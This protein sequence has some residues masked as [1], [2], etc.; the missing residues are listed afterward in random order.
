MLSSYSGFS[1]CEA[2]RPLL[3]HVLEPD[4]EAP[5]RPRGCRE[6]RC[7]SGYLSDNWQSATDIAKH[8]ERAS[9]LTAQHTYT[10]SGDHNSSLSLAEGVLS[11]IRRSFALQRATGGLP[12][13]NDP[14]SRS[15]S[16]PPSNSR[17]LSP[18]TK[19]AGS[20]GSSRLEERLRASL[21]KGTTVPS[22]SSTPNHESQTPSESP[23]EAG[24]SDALP[25]PHARIDQ[26]T[27]PS[28]ILGLDP[29]TIPLPPSPQPS[30]FVGQ[31][32][33]RLV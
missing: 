9:T 6:Q 5:R 24:L 30:Q 25:L 23:V 4:Q 16:P 17:E 26:K 2:L 27:T 32:L 28:T 8:S 21:N 13:S 15:K 18:V 11:S 10:S 19:R 31:T 22:R 1:L 12:T 7:S 3:Q 20:T 14:L 29:A 33:S